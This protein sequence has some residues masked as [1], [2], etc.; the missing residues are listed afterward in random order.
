[1]LSPPSPPL[2]NSMMCVK[3][4]TLTETVP[5]WAVQKWGGTRH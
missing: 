1:M 4:E 2:A 3:G 5:N